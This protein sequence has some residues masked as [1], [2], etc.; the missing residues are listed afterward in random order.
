MMKASKGIE[1]SKN[2]QKKKKITP[3]KREKTQR[4]VHEGKC[5]IFR[6]YENTW[7][8]QFD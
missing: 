5:T 2:Q 8:K 1:K 4:A 7:Q 6:E 3:A